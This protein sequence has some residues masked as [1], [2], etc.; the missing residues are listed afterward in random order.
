[1]NWIKEGKCLSLSVHMD[2]EEGYGE[3]AGRGY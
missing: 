1:M 2:R 3:R